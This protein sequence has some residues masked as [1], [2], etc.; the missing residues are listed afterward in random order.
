MMARQMFKPSDADKNTVRTMAACGINHE[1]IARC[2]GDH[3]VDDKTLRKHFA[4][5]LATSAEKANAAVASQVYQAAM[6]GEAWA[7]CFWLKCRAHWQETQAYRLTD[8]SGNDRNI[9]VEIEYLAANPP[10]TP[11]T[12]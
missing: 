4:E 6:R 12:T 5:E 9:T 1:R 7:C 8:E 10:K 2:I 11:G 3:G